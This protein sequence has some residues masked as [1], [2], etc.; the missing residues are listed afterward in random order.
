MENGNIPQEAVSLSK[1]TQLPVMVG[2]QHDSFGDDITVVNIPETVL[3][4]YKESVKCNFIQTFDYTNEFVNLQENV[5]L[6]VFSPSGTKIIPA[7]RIKE[8]H[9]LRY[10]CRFY[11]SGK[12][13]FSIV[14]NQNL[15]LDE[16]IFTVL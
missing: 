10:R 2:Q 11:E 4:N 6:N 9:V 8:N 14:Q 1:D 12:Y 13:H 3:L 15:I 16:G 5:V 7:P